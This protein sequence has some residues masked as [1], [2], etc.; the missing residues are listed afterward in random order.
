MSGFPTDWSDPN[1]LETN[2]IGPKAIDAAQQLADRGYEVLAG[3]NSEFAAQILTMSGEPAIREY[4]PKDL[5]ERF[6]DQAATQ[7][8]LSKQRAVYLLIKQGEQELAGY[9]WAGPA[10]SSNVP[11]G[12]T[13]FALRIGESGHGQGLAAPFSWLIMAAT[14]VHYGAQ[15]F[16]LETWSSNGAAVHIY[17]KLGFENTTEVPS[18]RLTLNGE[19]ISDTRLFMT[20]P[21]L[22]L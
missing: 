12:E 13:T 7:K 1:I 14:A 20:L 17:Q 2:N 6:T 8:W 22:K 11:G 5:S 19:K 16:W 10:S 18:K 3:L 21:R 15:N 9:G 4:C